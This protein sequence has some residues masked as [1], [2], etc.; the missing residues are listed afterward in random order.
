MGHALTIYKINKIIFQLEL[1]KK[2]IV[3]NRLRRFDL[4][5]SFTVLR[6]AC[7]VKKGIYGVKCIKLGVHQYCHLRNK[8]HVFKETFSQ[9][10][11]H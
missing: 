9:N 10:I 8:I 1:P 5:I 2:N 6:N 11:F 4:T 7:Y 3:I